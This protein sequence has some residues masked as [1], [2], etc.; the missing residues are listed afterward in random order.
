MTLAVVIVTAYLLGSF[1]TSYIVVHQLTGR[2]IR[3]MGSLPCSFIAM[4]APGQIWNVEQNHLEYRL[5]E[6]NRE[7]ARR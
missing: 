2:D 5:I 4:V 3:T 7:E 1:P 6:R